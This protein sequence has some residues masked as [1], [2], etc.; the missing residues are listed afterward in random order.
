MTVLEPSAGDG[1][2][3]GLAVRLGATVDCVELCG[4]LADRLARLRPVSLGQVRRLP[5][6]VAP[7]PV[8]D[9]VL[10]NPP[11]AGQA[12]IRHVTHALGFLKPGGL[13]VAVMSAGVT[14]R[15]DKLAAGLRELVTERGG[16][17]DPLPPD[18]FK[19]S[20]TSVRTVTVMIPAAEP[21]ADC[22]ICQLPISEGERVEDY[23]GLMT[24]YVCAAQKWAADLD[25]RCQAAAR[26]RD[27]VGPA[28]QLDLFAG[29]Q[30]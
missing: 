5:V 28:A 30:A 24:H 17:I 25:R 11:F 9:R 23:A 4:Q 26:E 7:E 10:M 29:S 3:A 13:L 27:H 2:I 20:G 19:Q 16:R 14:F 12:D 22:G 6:E 18:A 15:E 8:Y 1:A 21:V